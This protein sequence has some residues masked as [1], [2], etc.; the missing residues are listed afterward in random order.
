MSKRVMTEAEQRRA[1]LLWSYEQAVHLSVFGVD[2][3]IMS[4]ARTMA[5]SF[6]EQ[7]KAEYEILEWEQT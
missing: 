2:P 3:L 1:S 6:R 7:I 4:M 5:D